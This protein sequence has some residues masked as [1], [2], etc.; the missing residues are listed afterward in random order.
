VLRTTPRVIGISNERGGGIARGGLL[1]VAS[2]LYR[3]CVR[4]SALRCK[5]RTYRTSYV[6][7][8]NTDRPSK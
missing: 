4:N 6:G 7:T 5:R 2:L 3:E 8:V 1:V